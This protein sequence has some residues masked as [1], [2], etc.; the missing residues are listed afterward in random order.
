M[1]VT[2]IRYQPLATS[3]PQVR[4]SSPLVPAFAN[5][6]LPHL[7][8]SSH[9]HPLLPG[10]PTNSNKVDLFHSYAPFVAHFTHSAAQR[11]F[12]ITPCR[13]I[14]RLGDTRLRDA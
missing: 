6:R 12:M 3:V 13:D 10:V 4:E 11:A 5:F 9:P 8:A 1:R 14:M 2:T 7:F